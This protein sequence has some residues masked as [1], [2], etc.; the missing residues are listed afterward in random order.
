M[1]KRTLGALVVAAAAAFLL[2]L[3][4]CRCDQRGQP[5]LDLMRSPYAPERVPP[6]DAC[7]ESDV[8]VSGGWCLEPDPSGEHIAPGRPLA[9]HHVPAD[10]G[11]AA[12]IARIVRADETL[13]DIGAGIGQYQVW[14]W[15][16]DVH[17]ARYLAFDAAPNVEAFTGGAVRFLDAAR[18]VHWMPHEISDWVMSLEVGEHIPAAAEDI[19]LDNLDRANRKGI[20]LSWGVPGQDGHAHINLQDNAHVVFKMLERGYA[21]DEAA[22]ARGRSDAEYFW[23]KDTFMVF[24]RSAPPALGPD[25]SVDT[26]VRGG[27]QPDPSH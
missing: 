7:A 24:R 2:G 23:F 18:R 8:A 3:L 14:F 5:L 12:T 22:S 13:L 17:F 10:A 20:I 1:H 4:A 6:T 27:S 21:L 15:R 16:N 26:P 19:F 25:V 11:I 9:L